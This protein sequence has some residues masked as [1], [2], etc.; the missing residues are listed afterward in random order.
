MT[1]CAVGSEERDSDT[2]FEG[3]RGR[4][5]LAKD[6]GDRDVREGARIGFDQCPDEISFTGRYIDRAFSTAFF[7][8]ANALYATRTTIQAREDFAIDLIDLTAK[9]RQLVA[10]LRIGVLCRSLLAVRLLGSRHHERS[11]SPFRIPEHRRF[12]GGRLAYLVAVISCPS[13][14]ARLSSHPDGATRFSAG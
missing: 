2:L 4:N 9:Q 7:Q 6:V 10:N 1:E 3:T 14:S 8:L 11:F 13:E 5:D 12:R